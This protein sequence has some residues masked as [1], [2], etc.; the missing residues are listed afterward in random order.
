M[1]Q[2]LFPD[3][4]RLWDRIDLNPDYCSVLKLSRVVTSYEY[5]LLIVLRVF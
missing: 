2:S 4:T 1:L 3:V 5:S